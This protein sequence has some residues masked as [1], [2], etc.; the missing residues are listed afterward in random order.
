LPDSTG[1]DP[2]HYA[3]VFERMPR[4]RNLAKLLSPIIS[5]EQ[6]SESVPGLAVEKKVLTHLCR[7]YHTVH[8]PIPTGTPLPLPHI[9]SSLKSEHRRLCRLSF[10]RPSSSTSG[11][12]ARSHWKGAS[13]AH[14]PSR[15]R[16]TP[17]PAATL[18]TAY[19][20]EVTIPILG[21]L[22][23]TWVGWY[24]FCCPIFHGSDLS[25][26]AWYAKCRQETRRTQKRILPD[27][28]IV[29]GRGRLCRRV[30]KGQRA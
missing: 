14:A 15:C 11:S 23:T 16:S 17:A 21:A 13:T 24:V 25:H 26:P 27:G 12:S 5:E 19:P 1:V 28:N 20:R 10:P 30:T 29:G 7:K 18:A 8:L 4:H 9:T 6:R 3:H 2:C 22:L